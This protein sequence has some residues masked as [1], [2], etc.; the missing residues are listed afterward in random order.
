MV[1][2]T[3]YVLILYI[4]HYRVCIC[5]CFRQ[6]VSGESSVVDN[7]VDAKLEACCRL[8][9]VSKVFLPKL[10]KVLN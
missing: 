7:V 4:V 3:Y 9:F 5:E 8:A 6:S 1:A 10:P 2:S